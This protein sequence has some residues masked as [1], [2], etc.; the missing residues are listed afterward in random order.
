M[1]GYLSG[2]CIKKLHC[3]RRL[4]NEMTADVCRLRNINFSKLKEPRIGYADQLNIQASRVDL[5]TAG[6]IHYSL[7]PGMLIRYVKGEYVGESRDVSQIIKHVLPYIDEADVAHI[8]R[9]LTKGCPSIINF[10][11]ASDMKS[12]IIDKGNQATFKMY[13]EIVTKTMNKE[14]RY[15]HLLTVKLCVLYFSPWCRHT[16]QGIL[17]KPGKNPRVI[18]DASTKGSPHEVVLNEITPTEL[19]A[20]IDFG[21]ANMKLLIR[22]YNLRISYPQ[23]KILLHASAFRGC[24]QM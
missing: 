14:D 16:A 9:I 21:L 3:L 19:E 22:I 8:E 5:A 17:V 20:N 13:P 11:E 10:K 12:F 15:S 23:L 4:F 18:F 7:H 6:I 24:T 2:T 1:E